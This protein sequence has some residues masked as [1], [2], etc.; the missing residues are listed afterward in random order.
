MGSF[1]SFLHWS[2]EWRGKGKVT[3]RAKEREGERWHDRE[4]DTGGE[5]EQKDAC[6]EEQLW[7]TSVLLAGSL[8]DTCPVNYFFLLW[9]GGIQF[10]TSFFSSTFHISLWG[11]ERWAICCKCMMN[12][13]KYS[14]L[15][16]KITGDLQNR[17]PTYPEQ[18]WHTEQRC[19]ICQKLKAVL[20]TSGP[21]WF[22]FLF[23]SRTWFY[24]NNDSYMFYSCAF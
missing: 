19:E 2:K 20:V 12:F 5:E 16:L 1:L 3:H 14:Q 6:G 11:W 24:W 9:W 18:I 15:L 4:N 7:N 8:A 21:L 13:I 22:I 17:N 10:I 23:L